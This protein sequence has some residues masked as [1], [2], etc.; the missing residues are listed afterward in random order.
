M[1]PTQTATW[2]RPRPTR[3]V[4]PAATRPM[5]VWSSCRGG[6]FDYTPNPHFNGLDGFVYEICDTLCACDTAT[7][8]IT[9]SADL[10]RYAVG[11]VITFTGVDQTAPLGSGRHL[12]QTS[13]LRW[14]SRRR[15]RIKSSLPLHRLL[16]RIVTCSPQTLDL[17]A[18]LKWNSL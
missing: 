15:L 7:V 18:T 6:T 3:V 8:T 2:I 9:F 12:Y 10:M 14:P 1:T 17:S 13:S 16:A 11:G 5:A 4:P